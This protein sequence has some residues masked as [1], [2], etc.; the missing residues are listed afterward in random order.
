MGVNPTKNERPGSQ[1]TSAVIRIADG[2]PFTP[3]CVMTNAPFDLKARAH[4]ALLDAG[5]HPDFSADVVRETQAVK[6]A[7]PQITGTVRDLRSL[8]WSSI[9]NDSSRDLD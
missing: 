1:T 7:T 8:L 5:F 4:Q 3:R 9:D 6:P 2:G